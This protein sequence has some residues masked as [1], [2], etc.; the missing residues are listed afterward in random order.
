[1]MTIDGIDKEPN[2]SVR[3][4]N[5]VDDDET[6]YPTSL[7]AVAQAQPANAT[8]ASDPLDPDPP[9]ASASSRKLRRLRRDEQFIEPSIAT[10]PE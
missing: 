3:H 4:E 5:A 9:T 2:G 7:N 8:N 6:A 10:A 1:M